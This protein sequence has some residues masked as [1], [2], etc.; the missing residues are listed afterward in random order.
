MSSDDGSENNVTGFK[1][2][3]CGM[4]HDHLPMEFG[5]DAPS[6]YNTI[7]EDERD[8]RCDLNE[9]LCMIDDEFF[10]IRGCLELPV[11]DND[12]PFIWGVWASLSKESVKRCYEIWD[13]EGRE[14]EPPFFGW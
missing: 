5:A 11:I 13:Q 6:I 3:T 14:S 7:P 10:F 4:L 9:D 2:A 1:C 8:A 12:E